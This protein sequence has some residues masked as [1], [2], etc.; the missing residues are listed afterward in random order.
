MASRL[1]DEIA[2][3]NESG[4]YG[5]ILGGVDPEDWTRQKEIAR[6]R[7]GFVWPTFGVHPWTVAKLAS[8]APDG[9]RV[10]E[11]ESLLRSELEAARGE[12]VG[13]GETGLDFHPRF[14]LS[15]HPEQMR[16]FRAHLR[17]AAE[18]RLPA[19]LHI[20]RAHSQALEILREEAE[21]IE[22]RNAL[23]P[24]GRGLV[25]SFSGDLDQA[26][27][28]LALGFTPSISAPVI[29]RN[30]GT[31]FEKLRRAVVTLRATEFVIETDAPDQPPA[32][33]G[34]PNRLTSLRRVAE[35]L[36]NLRGGNSEDLLDESTRT[37]RR[38]FRLPASF[39]ANDL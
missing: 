25:H 5:F 7:P 29:T 34:G 19:V 20:V 26:R 22:W 39:S 1:G 12:C 8:E 9:K 27:A 31:A 35:T 11:A 37:L 15:T 32:G 30:S 28:Y 21:R 23:F 16:S 17:L 3:A 38:I 33:E 4:I 18:F 2:A 13:I 36:A 10:K 24:G 6:S 14:N